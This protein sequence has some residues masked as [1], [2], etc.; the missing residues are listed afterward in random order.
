MWEHRLDYDHTRRR[1][2]RYEAYMCTKLFGTHEAYTVLPNAYPYLPH[3]KVFWV[4]PRYNRYYSFTRIKSMIYTLYPNATNIFENP[5]PK[6]S[7]PGI[8][9]VHFQVF[10]SVKTPHIKSLARS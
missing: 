9:H 5:K 7:I 4:H 2:P 10:P 6:K 8:K 3:H 1:I